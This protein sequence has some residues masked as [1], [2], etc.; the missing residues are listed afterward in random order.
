[1]KRKFLSLLA[2][3]L[4]LSMTAAGCSSDTNSGEADGSDTGSFKVIGEDETES[5]ADSTDGSGDVTTTFAEIEPGEVITDADGSAVT[6]IDGGT[7]TAPA[8]TEPAD[9]KTLSEEEILAAMTSQS[10]TPNLTITRTDTER[11]G[12][13]TLNAEEKKLYD[14]IVDGIENLRY[15]IAA[16]DAYSIETWTKVYGMVYNQ[17]PRLFYM[18]PKVKVGKL[19]YTTKSSDVI[20]QMQK[21]IDATADKLVQEAAGKSSTFEKLKVFHDY[22]VLNSTFQ[23]SETNQDYNTSI[24]NAFGSGE[25]QGNIQCNGYAKSMQYLCDKAGIVSMVVTG[26]NDKGESHAWNV[27]DVDGKW[28]NLDCTWDDPRIDPPLYNNIRYANF[29]VPDKWIHNISHFHVNEHK[30]SSGKY[31]KY[32]DPPACV[33]TDQNYFIKNGLVYSDFDS[34]EKALKAEIKKAAENKAC[35]AHVMVSSKD[36]YDKL[37]AKGK[38]YQTYA[39]EFSGVRGINYTAS[40]EAMLL[41]EYDVL[42]N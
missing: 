22:L 3:V 18:G 34:A 24:Y 13:S 30:L 20:N 11:Y 25:A 32:F 37:I 36:I 38:E 8:Q 17:E 15:K 31:I 7:L 1:M 19:F 14:D 42:Y 21:D 2:L 39:R 33:D 6:G 40:C 27:V 5:G 41:V 23:Y 12:Y 35:A 28:Y 26:E 10:T 29:L 9:T 4:A 16:D